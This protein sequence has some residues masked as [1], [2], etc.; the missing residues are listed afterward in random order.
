MYCFKEC[1]SGKKGEI[2]DYRMNGRL[3]ASKEECRRKR[4]QKDKGKE[5]IVVI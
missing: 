4:F 5:E 1:W 3:E 2:S